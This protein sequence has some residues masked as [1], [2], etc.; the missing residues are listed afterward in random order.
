MFDQKLQSKDDASTV[1]TVSTAGLTRNLRFSLECNEVF[2]II[3]RSEMTEKDVFETWYGPQDYDRMKKKII[4]IV[5]KMMSGEAVEETK[6]QTTRGLEYRHREGA[7]QREDNK[8]DAAGAVLGE[9]QR[10]RRKKIRD[11]QRIADLYQETSIQCQEEA[12][13]LGLKDEKFIEDDLKNMRRIM[14][15][16][17]ASRNGFK[18][19]SLGLNKFLKQVRQ[20]AKRSMDIGNREQEKQIALVA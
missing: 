8:K 6:K 2:P 12:H 20:R 10:Q 3:P 15:D 18:S 14:S 5:K 4:P 17:K 13:S 7:M 11:E 19:K 16:P 1:A 9:Q